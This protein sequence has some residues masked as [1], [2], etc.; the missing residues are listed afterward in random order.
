[1]SREYVRLYRDHPD[2][3][4]RFTAPTEAFLGAPV[5]TGT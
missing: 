3:V 2:I 5:R 4:G 1:M